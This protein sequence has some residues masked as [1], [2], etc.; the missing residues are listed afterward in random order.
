MAS[1]PTGLA[2]LPPPTPLEDWLGSLLHDFNPG[3]I[4][5]AG[6]PA[7]LP[8]PRSAG[9]TGADEPAKTGVPSPQKAPPAPLLLLCHQAPQPRGGEPRQ[10]QPRL[11][12]HVIGHRQRVTAERLTEHLQTRGQL[13]THRS[14]YRRCVYSASPIGHAAVSALPVRCTT[15]LTCG[16]NS[17]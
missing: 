8:V 11:H 4:F 2:G 13:L 9:G 3:G 17:P 12:H 5:A 15:R 10:R 14:V 16:A 7:S 1:S 6:P